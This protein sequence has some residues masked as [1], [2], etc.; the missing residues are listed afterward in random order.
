MLRIE[1]VTV[2]GSPMEVWIYEPAGDGPV[3][4][5]V[6]AMHI[7]GHA[8][9]DTDE[10]TKAAAQRLADAGYLV[11]V[12]YIFHWWPKSDGIEVKRDGFRD[13]WTIRDLRA[14][15]DLLEGI[16]RVDATRIGIAGHC[17]GGRIAW[18]G[19]A[20]DPRFRAC[21]VFYGGR[22][23]L[24]LGPDSRPAIDR[25]PDIRCP[26]AGFFGNDDSNPSPEDVDAYEAA[27]KAAGVP[28]EFHRYDG[29]GHAFQS[30]TN[31]DRYRPAQSDDAWVKAIA[32]LGRSL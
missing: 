21:I 28:H 2:D 22:I 26:V 14:T 19:A 31:P 16:E 1:T 6:L 11:A 27:L 9:I 5:L 23:R 30:F 24:P 15:V 32:F 12:P 7:P 17:W 29:A 13:D 4:A 3:P 8:A 25:A 18:L 10:F 20:T